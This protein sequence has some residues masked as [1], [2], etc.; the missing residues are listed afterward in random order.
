MS[1]S[2]FVM[3]LGFNKN[4]RSLSGIAVWQAM[5]GAKRSLIALNIEKLC[6][7]ENNTLDVFDFNKY[8]DF[9]VNIK[10]P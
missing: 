1:V 9:S 6:F 7:R 4:W 2:R 3:F 5:R 8:D 10:F